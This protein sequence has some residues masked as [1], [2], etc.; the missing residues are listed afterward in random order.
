[1]ALRYGCNSIEC[2]FGQKTGEPGRLA[3]FPNLVIIAEDPLNYVPFVC[4][5]GALKRMPVF[6]A[7]IVANDV[8]C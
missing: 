1:M 4:R 8:G 5:N 6:F 2:K 7:S 3:K